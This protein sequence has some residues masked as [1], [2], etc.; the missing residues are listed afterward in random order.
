MEGSPIGKSVIDNLTVVVLTFNEEIHIA[1]CLES[2]KKL[3]DNILVLDSY[4]ADRTQEIC[5]SYGVKLHYNKFENFSSQRN[6][7][8]SFV[9]T[10][11]LL[12]V[13]ADEVLDDDLIKSINCLEIGEV[14]G[15]L[16]NRKFVFYGKWIKYG[17]Y[18]PSYNLRLF[19]KNKVTINREINEHIMCSGR[20]AMLEGHLIDINLHG[21]SGW[22]DKHNKYSSFESKMNDVE[23]NSGNLLGN[24]IERKRWFRERIWSR[25]PL[26]FRSLIYF[27]YR[28]VIR[29]GFRDGTV[30]AFYHFNHA[31][32]YRLWIDFKMKYDE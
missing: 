9:K 15:F 7:A 18:Y 11:W 22:I 28:Y 6:K 17:G 5:I 4:S 14:D 27:L 13:D 2:I 8:I 31:L 30:G 23:G 32:V 21:L 25:L 24:V 1:R 3:T 12:F 19:N 20:T 29:G 26:G 10:D 16:L